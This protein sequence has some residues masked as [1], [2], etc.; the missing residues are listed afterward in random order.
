MNQCLFFFFPTN[1]LSDFNLPSL[2]A[3]LNDQANGKAGMRYW[4]M[5]LFLLLC[6]G[7]G[8]LFVVCF[9]L[10]VRFY[11]RARKK[12]ND[13]GWLDRWF[14]GFGGREESEGCVRPTRPASFVV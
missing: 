10:F 13:F 14:V 4:N 11:E 6:L 5:I 3:D 8:F 1:D 7:L 9:L 12:K 2:L